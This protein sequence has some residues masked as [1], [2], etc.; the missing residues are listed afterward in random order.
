MDSSRIGT[1]KSKNYHHLRP[2]I[3]HKFIG[4]LIMKHAVRRFW[5]ILTLAIKMR[6]FCLLLTD[7]QQCCV[8]FLAG[9]R[10]EIISVFYRRG[11]LFV[12][13]L[14]PVFIGGICRREVKEDVRRWRFASGQAASIS[15]THC[16]T[17]LHD[18][19]C[20]R[21]REEENSGHWKCSRLKAERERFHLFHFFLFIIGLQS[22]ISHLSLITR[23]W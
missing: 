1:L 18:W 13:T 3:V 16:D 4:H 23:R 8:F 7:M 9:G 12:S 20:S 17:T 19:R 2:I 21:R 14:M 15:I 5:I 10:D 6:L 22:N 11:G